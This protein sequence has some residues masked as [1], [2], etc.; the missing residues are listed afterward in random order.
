ML[1]N[2]LEKYLP[3]V[4]QRIVDDT[5]RSTFSGKERRRLELYDAEKHTLLYQFLLCDDGSGHIADKMRLLHEKAV[6][7]I[8]LEEKRRKKQMAITEASITY[9]GEQSHNASS[10]HPAGSV[11]GSIKKG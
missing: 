9:G 1:D 3:L 6:I 10:P 7:E 8:E 5:L 2:Y 11:G 4:T